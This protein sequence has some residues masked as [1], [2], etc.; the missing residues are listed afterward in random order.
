MSKGFIVW[1]SE[2][3]SAQLPQQLAE[4]TRIASDFHPGSLFPFSA[5]L[6]FHGNWFCDTCVQPAQFHSERFQ[7]RTATTRTKLVPW[8]AAEP[9]APRGHPAALETLSPAP[10]VP[11]GMEWGAGHNFLQTL[12]PRGRV[13]G[14]ALS[15]RCPGAERVEGNP[16]AFLSQNP[17]RI[18][19]LRRRLLARP[20]FGGCI[21]GP[22]PPAARCSPLRPAP[23]GHF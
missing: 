22:L 8:T 19:L 3:N 9:R 16:A 2:P 7:L 17:P 4:S 1:P 11:R 20:R 15:P 21:A 10:R 12:P 18:L 23:P 14:M 6:A 5:L 13:P